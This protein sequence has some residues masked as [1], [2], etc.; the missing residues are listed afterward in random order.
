MKALLVIDMQKL[1]FIP[2][3]PRYDT[4]GVI[5]RINHLANFF[6]EN[7]NPVIFIQHDGSKDGFCIP[8]TW[9]WEILD[10]LIRMDTDKVI[11]KSANDPFYNTEL[12]K[13]LK[14]LGINELIITGCASDF[15]VDT[16]VKSALSLNYKVTVATDAHTTADRPFLKAHDVIA[17]Y[18]WIWSEM[19]P[20]QTKIELLTA[21]EILN[22]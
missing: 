13:H 16:A 5:E 6:R 22:G 10:E 1:S 9:E 7:G 19:L 20:T 21:K 3:T 15:C 17:Y 12:D 8:N 2:E 14:T 4:N 18:N 11:A